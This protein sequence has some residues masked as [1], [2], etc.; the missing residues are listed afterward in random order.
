MYVPKAG[1]GSVAQGKF[2]EVKAIFWRSS[3]RIALR[4]WIP[5]RACG[6]CAE[7]CVCFEEVIKPKFTLP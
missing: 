3:I 2:L 7:K 1:G 5:L 6:N 4:G